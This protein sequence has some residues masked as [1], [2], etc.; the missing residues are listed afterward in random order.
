MV[1]LI[2][3]VFPDLRVFTNI[4]KSF[5]TVIVLPFIMGMPVQKE[6]MFSIV[7]IIW[8]SVH[9]VC[10]VYRLTIRF[11]YPI[12]FG[13]PIRSS[14]PV[15]AFYEFKIQSI[16]ILSLVFLFYLYFLSSA[17]LEHL[18]NTMVSLKQVFYKSLFFSR[19]YPN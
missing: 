1:I 2:L 19:F 10:V 12:A 7:T 13:C 6:T 5:M 11:P 17:D 3:L 15:L 14:Q 4:V 8:L 18:I 9:P 16:F